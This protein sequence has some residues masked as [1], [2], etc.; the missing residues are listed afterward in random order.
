MPNI[1]AASPRRQSDPL[2]ILGEASDLVSISGL[3]LDGLLSKMADLVRKVVEYQVFSV[4]LQAD[5]LGLFRIRYAIG[6]RDELIRKL[7]VRAGDGIT[8]AAVEARDTVIANDVSRDPR[9]IVGVDAIRSELAVPLMARGRVIG[10]VDVQSTQLDAFGDYER[11][12]VEL[13]SSRFSLAI[14]GA[15]LLRAAIRQNRTLRTLAQVAQEFSQILNLDDLVNQISSMMRQLIP[16]DAFNVFLVEENGHTLKHH[17]GVRYDK[18]VQWQSMEFGEGIVGTAAET[19]SPVLVRDTREDR[20]YVAATDGI[21]S[22]AAMPLILK[23]RLIGVLDLESE[24]LGAF[25]ARHIQVL[26][27][28]APQIA[29]A[30]ENARLY[31]RVARNEARLERDLKAARDLQRNLLAA[32]S[33]EFS[34]IE[35]AGRNVG[36]SEVTGDL[37]DFFPF[38]ESH[39]N[40]LLGDVSGKGAAAALYGALA[41]GLLRNVMRERYSPAELL[42]KT[43]EALLARRIEARYLTAVAVQWKPASHEVVIANAGQPRPAICRG[44]KVEIPVISGVPLGLIEG[45]EYENLTLP[46]EPGD[47]IVLVSDGITEATDRA[48]VQYGDERLPQIVEAHSKASASGLLD[49]IFSDVAMFAAGGRQ[50]DDRTVIVAKITG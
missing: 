23:D 30:I 22:E 27:L 15:R 49:T 34:G 8:G 21:L 33:P 46:V 12:M 17:F 1:P 26:S 16:H 5:E 11:S 41:S 28:L 13:I 37:F 19:R 39:L 25:S 6:I 43:N 24:K 32:A 31:E 29:T 47:L 48:R 10:I 50:D 9:Y 20:R 18:R 14:D 40:M 45:S 35:I 44:G 36:A 4:L 2:E 7:Q 3:D 42:G 38:G